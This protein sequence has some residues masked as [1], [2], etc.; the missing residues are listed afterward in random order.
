MRLPHDLYFLSPGSIKADTGAR[1]KQIWRLASN[2]VTLTEITHEDYDVEEFDVSPVTG[3]VAYVTD[4]LHHNQLIL[5]RPDGSRRQV[6]VN[7][8]PTDEWGSN[9]VDSL[10]WSPGGQIL[11]YHHDGIILYQVQTGQTVKVFADH[12]DEYQRYSP[13]FWSPDGQ[14]LLVKQGGY[15]GGWWM[16]YNLKEKTLT[17]LNGPNAHGTASWSADSRLAV[18]SSSYLMGDDCVDLLQFDVFAQ[19]GTTL[20]PCQAS[21]ESYSNSDWP[22]LTSSN[23]LLYFYN[24]AESYGTEYGNVPWTIMHAKLGEGNA[25]VLLRSSIPVGVSEVLW[26]GDGNL[27]IVSFSDGPDGPIALV[28]VDKSQP[29]QLLASEGKNLRWGP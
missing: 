1:P 10:R 18:F 7:D 20:I 17:E 27:A 6:I 8:G 24:Y 13:E 26:A 9:W 4:Q 3:R 21:R 25:P 14:H 5:I 22:L 23:D 29:L 11:A 19:I 28:P 2:G 16:L 12:P 15:E